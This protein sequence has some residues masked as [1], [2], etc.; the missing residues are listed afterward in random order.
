MNMTTV[1]GELPYN[2]FHE[3]ITWL[4]LASKVL[5]DSWQQ[6]TVETA[7]SQYYL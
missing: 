7:V 5:G 3:A 2:G 6:N 1:S 4:S